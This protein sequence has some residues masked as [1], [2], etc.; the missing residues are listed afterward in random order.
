MPVTL[1]LTRE[2]GPPERIT[3]PVEIWFRGDRYTLEVPGNAQVTAAR[4]DPA[5]KLPDLNRDNNRWPAGAP[6][7]P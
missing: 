6:P 5:G 2:V 1:E 4:I 7:G 3:L